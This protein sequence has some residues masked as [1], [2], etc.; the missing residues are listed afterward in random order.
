[1]DKGLERE[2]KQLGLHPPGP[3]M[4]PQDEARDMGATCHDCG[5][6]QVVYLIAKPLAG[7]FPAGAYC[8]DCLV[9]RCRASRI[10][11]Y[12][13]E[14]GLLARIKESL[15]LPPDAAPIFTHE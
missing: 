11:P 1:M 2:L 15:G 8:Y 7:L 12:P 10:I 9:K 4:L 13:I 6:R 5:S 14:A 3:F